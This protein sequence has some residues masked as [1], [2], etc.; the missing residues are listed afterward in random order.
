VQTNRLEHL[1]ECLIQVIGRVALPEQKVRD[2]VGAGSKQIRAFNL[3][4]G[5]RQLSD[6]ASTTGIDNGNLSRTAQRWVENG[7]AFWVGEKSDARLLH[8]YPI[9]SS[10]VPAAEKQRQRRKRSRK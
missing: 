9:T 4:D 1:V 8:I 6:I 5:T 10:S 3:A 7:A 2:L